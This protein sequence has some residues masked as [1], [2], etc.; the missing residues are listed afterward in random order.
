MREHPD[1]LACSNPIEEIIDE[2]VVERNNFIM[3]GSRK[4]PTSLAYELTNIYDLELDEQEI[5][6]MNISLMKR[7]CLQHRDREISTN[8]DTITK[9]EI[10]IKQNQVAAAS[11]IPEIGTEVIRPVQLKKSP[12]YIQSL[13]SLLNPK[14]VDCYDDWFKVGAII[15]NED[16][17]YIGLW[18]EWSKQSSKYKES[19]IGRAHV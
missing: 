16:E 2:C 17:E 4:K 11:I 18:K 5:P 9:S 15:Y 10:Q 6:E 3:Y 13:L 19:Q 12:Q 8:I 1:I 14:R 7:I